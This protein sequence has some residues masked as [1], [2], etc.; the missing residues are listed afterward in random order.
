MELL[1]VF[2]VKEIPSEWENKTKFPC[3]VPAAICLV[4]I[5]VHVI[6]SWVLFKVSSIL[7]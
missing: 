5:S 1:Y 7:Y 4:S 6:V 2:K 3:D